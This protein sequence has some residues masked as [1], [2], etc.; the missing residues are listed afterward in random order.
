MGLTEAERQSDAKRATLRS[1]MAAVDAFRRELEGGPSLWDQKPVHEWDDVWFH[2]DQ[3][4][5]QL[6]RVAD[7]WHMPLGGLPER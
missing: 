2:A 3:A 1:A 7:E 6:H 4:Y 5:Q